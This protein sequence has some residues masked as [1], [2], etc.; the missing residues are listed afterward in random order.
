MLSSE[1]VAYCSGSITTWPNAVSA[2][3]CPFGLWQCSLAGRPPRYDHDWWGPR[4]VV[5]LSSR[6]LLSWTRFGLVF[7]MLSGS[8]SEMRDEQ[9]D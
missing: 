8:G 7:E 2:R 9:N 1:A 3:S 5:T 6:H 4:H